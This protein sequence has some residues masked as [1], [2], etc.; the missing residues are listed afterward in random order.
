ML[1]EKTHLFEVILMHTI[2]VYFNYSFVE[3]E[4]KHNI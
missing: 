3:V 2:Y 1:M 4:E